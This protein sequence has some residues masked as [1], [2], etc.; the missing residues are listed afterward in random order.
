MLFRNPVIAEPA[1]G[2]S[3]S[4]RT[5]LALLAAAC[6]WLAGCAS[7]PPVAVDY[8]PQANFSRLQTYYLLDPLAS[9]PVAPLEL[10]RARQAVEGQLQ[11]RYRPAASADAADF[12][13]RVQL[14]GTE[15]VAVYEDRF[16]VYGGH[17]PLGFGWQVPLN[18]RQYRQVHLVIDALSPEQVPL[19]RGSIPSRAMGARSPEEQQ[20]RL[21]NE[22]A[23]ILNRFPPY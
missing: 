15:R 23:L 14:Q 6:L 5:A 4:P 13:V 3:W 2:T 7:A 16:G 20:Q 17:G 1:A 21:Y 18:V 11:L 19:W 12:L 9:G 22:A 8:D 10:K